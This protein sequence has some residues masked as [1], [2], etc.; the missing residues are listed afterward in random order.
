MA[1]VAMRQPAEGSDIENAGFAAPFVFSGAGG[2]LVGHGA[3]CS[4]APTAAGSLA[5]AVEVFWKE[6]RHATLLVG[7]LPFDRTAAAHLYAPESVSAAAPIGKVRSLPRAAGGWTSIA[8]PPAATYADS[9]ARALALLNDEAAAL[10][11]VVLARSLLVTA[12]HAIDLDAVLTRLAQDS[13]ITTYAVP[14]P[15]AASGAPR[16]LVGASPE[17]LVD[18]RGGTVRSAPLAGSARRHADAAADRASADGL[19]HSEK[20]LREHAFVVEAILDT[21][22]PY[23]RALSAP[24]GPSL[25]STASMWHLGTA[26]D[27]ELKDPAVSVVELAAALHPT[28][29]VCGLPRATAREAIATLEDFDRGFYAGAVGWAD[30]AGDGRWMVAIRCA[31]FSGATARLYAGAGIVPGSDP[32]SEVAE[33][34]AKFAALLAALGIDEAGRTQEPR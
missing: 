31:E 24:E 6:Q 19:L 33:T 32:E 26:I 17:L 13:T 14:L 15:A 27:G 18:K 28:P 7:A 11:K 21:L 29:A 9:V 10:R 22:T 12:P 2:T 8:E 4:L 5:A 30:R 3:G 16:T 1:S 23:C 34:S 25:V 20:D